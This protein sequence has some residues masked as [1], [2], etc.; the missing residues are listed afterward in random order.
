MVMF[1]SYV[2]LPEGTYA[3]KWPFPNNLAPWS[4]K[5]LVFISS[6]WYHSCWILL[7]HPHIWPELRVWHQVKL[8]CIEEISIGWLAFRCPDI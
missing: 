4:E 8:R 7:T 6:P 5:N 2:N 1:H 3:C